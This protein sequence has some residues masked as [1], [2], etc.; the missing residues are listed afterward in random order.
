MVNG[1]AGGTGTTDIDETTLANIISNFSGNTV[2]GTVNG[3]S[4]QRTGTIDS[5]ATYKLFSRTSYPFSGKLYK[6]KCVK[7]NQIVRNLVPAVKKSN[8]NQLFDYTRTNG[9]IADKYINQSG[10]LVSANDYYLSYPISVTPGET[11]TWRFNADSS[12]TTHTAPTVGFYDAS[13]NLISTAQ[14]ASQIKYFNFTVPSNCAYIRCSVYT[15]NNAQQQ[16]M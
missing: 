2:S 15:V 7:N 13:D 1:G 3:E 5:S 12:S 6:A 9:I 4:F 8:G 10:A 16:A 11:Y 14:H